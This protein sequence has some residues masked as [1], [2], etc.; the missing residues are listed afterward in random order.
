MIQI[1]S[2]SDHTVENPELDDYTTHRHCVG[3]TKK[4]ENFIYV[5]LIQQLRRFVK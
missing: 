1:V 4:T 2:I 3:G 5:L